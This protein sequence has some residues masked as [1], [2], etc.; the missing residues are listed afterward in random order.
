MPSRYTRFRS[1]A[2]RAQSELVAQLLLVQR[3]Q[4]FRRLQEPRLQEPLLQEPLLQ[5]RRFREQL[6]ARRLARSPTGSM[7]RKGAHT[8]AKSEIANA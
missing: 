6:W 2:K 3:R 7:K 1:A 8:K 4:V 5:E